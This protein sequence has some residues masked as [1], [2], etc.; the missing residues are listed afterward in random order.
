VY[1][2]K[3]GER[4]GREGEDGRTGRL[5]R[6]RGREDV[7]SREEGRGGM[8]RRGEGEGWIGQWE[9]EGWGELRGRGDVAYMS[10]GGIDAP[11][12]DDFPVHHK[13]LDKTETVCQ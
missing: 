11:A 7:R 8:G 3:G 5:R 9:W 10:L 2:W 4:M 12:S 13:V 6:E 1:G